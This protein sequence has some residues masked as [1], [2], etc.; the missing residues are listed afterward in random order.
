[1]D[2]EK[3]IDN[4]VARFIGTKHERDV[5]RIQPLVEAVNALEPEMKQLSDEELGA[6]TLALKAEVQ[7]RMEGVEGDDPDYK[8]RLQEALEPAVVPAFATAREA[9]RRTLGMR[10]FDVQL[11]GGIVLHQGKI[12]EMKTGEGKTLTATLP[13]YLNALSGKSATLVT[14]NDYLAK[15]D[16][17]WM[18]QIFTSLGLTV[19]CLQNHME[20]AE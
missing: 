20:D 16:S 19:G 15:R 7:A 1:M 9:G 12:S 6:R 8:Q 17:E 3:V 14:V 18:A 4:V 2:V 10:H 5:K 11:I 13:L